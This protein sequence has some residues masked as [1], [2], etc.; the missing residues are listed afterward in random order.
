MSACP[1]VSA[2]ADTAAAHMDVEPVV[3]AAQAA[4]EAA[5]KILN[6]IH[7][8]Q[9]QAQEDLDQAAE[10]LAE[11]LHSVLS[12]MPRLDNETCQVLGAL[13]RFLP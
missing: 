5:V 6:L 12:W 11:A 1:D 10:Q 8:P 4:G 13:E 7:T 3:A 2:A 9:A